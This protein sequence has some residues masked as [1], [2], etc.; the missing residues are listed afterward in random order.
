MV[1]TIEPV[2]NKETKERFE[3]EDRGALYTGNIDHYP[4]RIIMQKTM[5]KGVIITGWAPNS[6]RI[7][8]SMNI[9][10]EELDKALDALDYALDYLDSQA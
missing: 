7:S 4:C 6:L 3:P 8:C 10:K 2:K 1:C 9:S 5:E